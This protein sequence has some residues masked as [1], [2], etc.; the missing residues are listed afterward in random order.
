MENKKPNNSLTLKRY[1]EQTKDLVLG[2][3]ANVALHLQKSVQ[4]Q[5]ELD[6]RTIGSLCRSLESLH[7]IAMETIKQSDKINDDSLFIGDQINPKFLINGIEEETKDSSTNKIQKEIDSEIW[8]INQLQN[9]LLPGLKN[10]DAESLESWTQLENLKITLLK[11]K[12]DESPDIIT[13]FYS[14]AE[15]DLIE[16]SKV[17]EVHEKYQEFKDCVY[18]IL[19]SAGDKII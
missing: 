4:H 13:S 10:S 18:N 19:Q 15:N 6:P 2:L 8:K 9:S 14:L 12:K 17:Q 3:Q 16:S 1:C 11:L 7:T 5:E